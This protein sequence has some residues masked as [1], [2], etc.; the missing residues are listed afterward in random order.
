[1]ASLG[2][3]TSK[4]SPEAAVIESP[5]TARTS[6]VE[7]GPTVTAASV[8]STTLPLPSRMMLAWVWSTTL[9]SLPVTVSPASPWPRMRVSPEAAETESPSPSIVAWAPGRRLIVVLSSEATSP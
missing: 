5:S 7:P 8:P 4:A 2:P 9:A 3:V 1:M 6:P